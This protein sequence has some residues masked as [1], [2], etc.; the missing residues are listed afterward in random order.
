IYSR[1]K[2]SQE[3][4]ILRTVYRQS[5]RYSTMILLPFALFLI[6]YGQ[7][8]MILFFGSAYS[9]GGIYL[10][11][12]ALGTLVVGMGWTGNVL[13]SQGDSRYT[14]LM[15]ILTSVVAA[16]IA[17]ATVPT[18]GLLAYVLAG[19]LAVMPAYVLLVRRA[20]SD[21]GISPPYSYVAPFYGALLL[22]GLVS[23]GLLVANLAPV[24]E[25]VGGA[26]VVAISFVVFC[27]VLRALTPVDAIRLREMLSTQRVVSKLAGPLIS[28]LGRII[29]F[30]QR[31]EE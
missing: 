27:V 16:A 26:F 6:I 31:V 7:P 29:R 28:L 23:A 8:F 11:A 20:R 22:S 3:V 5:V 1:I 4:D 15:G 9:G 14:G 19:N 30:V 21:L 18:L 10:T 13:S 2:G 12:M 17:I 25:V 24:I